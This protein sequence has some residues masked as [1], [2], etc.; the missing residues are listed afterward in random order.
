M[1]IGINGIKT[2][3]PEI[4]SFQLLIRTIPY[5]PVQVDESPLF[6]DDDLKTF[7]PPGSAITTF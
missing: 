5:L 4:I 3:H 1:V 6:P 7:Y 2:F